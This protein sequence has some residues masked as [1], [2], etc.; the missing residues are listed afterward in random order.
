MTQCQVSRPTAAGALSIAPGP[1][2]APGC[3]LGTP[4]RLRI[5]H[6]AIPLKVW[7]PG[8]IRTG[9]SATSAAYA[10]R[11]AL[12]RELPSPTGT[13]PPIHRTS[14]VVSMTQDTLRIRA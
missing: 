12:L 1:C 4:G 6:N 11:Q 8:Q 13:D 3:E 2:Q 14:S 5:R 7:V 9:P 10:G